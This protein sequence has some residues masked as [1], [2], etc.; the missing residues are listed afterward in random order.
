[1]DPVHYP[2]PTR[3]EAEGLP[4][5]GDAQ[6]ALET[7]VEEINAAVVPFLRILDATSRP[8]GQGADQ[9]KVSVG[10]TRRHVRRTPLPPLNRT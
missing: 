7:P 4:N 6:A 2:T 9:D 1:M 5:L 3:P 10:A 8:G